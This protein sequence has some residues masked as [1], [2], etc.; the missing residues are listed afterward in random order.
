MKTKLFLFSAVLLILG[1]C[2][3]T[4]DD[5]NNN[6]IDKQHASIGPVVMSPQA[7]S[8]SLDINVEMAASI[9]GST[10][11]YTT[12]GT[13]PTNAS[14]VY[15]SAIPVSG[16]GSTKTIKTMSVYTPDGSTSEESI[17]TYVINYSK[18]STLNTNASNYC[19]FYANAPMTYISITCLTPGAAIYYTTDGST[20]TSSSTHYV[21]PIT[22]SSPTFTSDVT[23]KAIGVKTG[24]QNS[25]VLTID[26]TYTPPVYYKI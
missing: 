26:C 6:G 25:D 13:T 22:I 9:T 15:S 4:N 17:N 7:G 24:L 23:I 19:S 1:A 10:I 18:V 12:D 20:P 21:S 14:S 16:N 11:Y 2:F 5:N 8:Y 3:Q